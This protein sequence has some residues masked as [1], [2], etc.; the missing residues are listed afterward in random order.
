VEVKVAVAR[1]AEE[2]A[3]AVRAAAVRAAAVRAGC[4]AG[5][6]TGALVHLGGP[7]HCARQ[8]STQQAA[9]QLNTPTK[10]IAAAR[11]EALGAWP[12]PAT[13]QPCL[14]WI[15]RDSTSWPPV[16]AGKG[17]QKEIKKMAL[18]RYSKPG[19]VTMPGSFAGVSCLTSVQLLRT[20][21]V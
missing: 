7:Y 14:G 1:V 3:A 17:V 6:D 2:R 18:V 11:I 20:K 10:A 5:S 8:V 4:S 15:R 9:S 19:E 12:R 16:E 21:T 13:A